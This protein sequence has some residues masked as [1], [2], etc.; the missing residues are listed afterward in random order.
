MPDLKELYGMVA[1]QVDPDIDAWPQQERRHRRAALGRRIET[2]AVVA[3]LAALLILSMTVG[4][5]DPSGVG[6]HP[7]P[8]AAVHAVVDLTNGG[9]TPLP[10]RIDGA[11][12]YSPSPDG[13]RLALSQWPSPIRDARRLAVYIADADGG[14]VR[15]VTPAGIDAIGPRWSTN[16][17]WIVYQ[18]RDRY[19][20]RIGNLFL[21]DVASGDITQVTDLPAISSGWWFMSPS[22][23]ADGGSII[24]HMPRPSRPDRWDLWSVPTTGGEPT[25]I[26]RDAAYGSALANGSIAYLENPRYGSLE[27]PA[28]LV[29]DEGIWVV[30]ADGS[31]PVS[32]LARDGVYLP[33]A[34]PDG[35]RIAYQ[36]GYEIHVI[37]SDVTARETTPD[38]VEG[39][40][41]FWLD[42]DTLIV[43]AP[44]V[45][46]SG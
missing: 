35:T 43:A 46:A 36:I 33:I 34:S 42:D 3:T 6:T 23:S 26:R 15:R 22:F 20:D 38:V 8:G 32:L 5:R 45:G 24:F 19:N 18:G 11:M 2:F 31:H 25:L 21:L 16:G 30:D 40:S 29:S 7:T 1:R 37:S 12:F 41:P 10:S 44:I 4:M 27:P 14:D 17:R 9:T 28:G 39:T 13:G